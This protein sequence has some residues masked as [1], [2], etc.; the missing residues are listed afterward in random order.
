MAQSQDYILN[1]NLETMQLNLIKMLNDEYDLKNCSNF[2][3]MGDG[4]IS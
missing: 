3:Y 4:C 2:N 1:E